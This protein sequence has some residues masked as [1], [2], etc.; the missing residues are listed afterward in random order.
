MTYTFSVDVDG[1]LNDYP[2]CWLNYIKQE[3]GF[4]YKSTDEA[5][6]RLGHAAYKK[7]KTDYRKSIFKEN[8]LFKDEARHSLIELVQMGFEIVAATSRP[9]INPEFPDLKNLTSRWIEKNLG[10]PIQVVYKNDLVD[11]TENFPNLKYHI[12]DELKYA[13]PIADKNVKVFLVG[14]NC[15]DPS[16][17]PN[18]TKISSFSQAISIIKVNA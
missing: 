7:I 4:E 3:T 12:D 1:V 14:Q 8:I 5:K 13:V 17:N 10:F 18:I 16:E 6:Q 9:L 2:A 11:F 15:K